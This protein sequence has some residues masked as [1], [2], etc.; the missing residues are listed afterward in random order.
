M[1]FL[2]KTMSLKGLLEEHFFPL[3]E[4]VAENSDDEEDNDIWRERL[5]V[6]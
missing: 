4:N 3:D 2:V 1:I 5:G 6:I